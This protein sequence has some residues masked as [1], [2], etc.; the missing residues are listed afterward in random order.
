M[1]TTAILWSVVGM[2]I[3]GRNTV[4]LKKCGGILSEARAS[5][6]THTR[7]RTADSVE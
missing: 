7:G 4:P 3:M 5:Q 2:G 1:H 6:P